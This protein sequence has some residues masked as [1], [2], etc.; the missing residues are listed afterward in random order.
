M[1]KFWRVI[2]SD[3]EMREWL[4]MDAKG[5]N[6]TGITWLLGASGCANNLNLNSYIPNASLTTPNKTIRE[7]SQVYV[8]YQIFI[9]N[10]RIKLIIPAIMQ[11]LLFDQISNIDV[12]ELSGFSQSSWCGCL[13]CPRCTSHQNVWLP[14]LDTVFHHD[15]DT[16]SNKLWNKFSKIAAL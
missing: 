5:L 10:V 7:Q 11:V 14:S 4:R 3:S 16:L 9:K 8:A 6:I 1:P 15:Y 2:I 12:V 13:S